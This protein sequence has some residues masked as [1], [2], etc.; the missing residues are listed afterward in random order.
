MAETNSSIILPAPLFTDPRSLKALANGTFYVGAVDTD[1]TS[2]TNQIPV[3]NRNEDGSLV[4]VSQPINIGTGGYPVFNGIPFAPIVDGNYSIAIFDAIGVQRFYFP[5]VSAYQP[6]SPSLSALADLTPAANKVPYFT[7]PDSAA[8]ADLTPFARE[9]LAQP[10][11]ASVVSKI[12]LQN[13]SKSRMTAFLTAGVVSFT[14]PDDV[15]RIYGRAIGG[16]G[17]A[18]GSASAKSGGGGGA[19]GYSEGYFNVTPGQVISITVGTQGAGGTPGNFG[20]SGGASSIG[21]FMSASG[22]AYGDAG[23]GGTG[24]GGFGGSGTGGTFNNVGG[25][26]ADGTTTGAVGGG[27]GGGAALGGST[28][29]GGTGRN[30]L[31]IGGGGAASYVAA[32]QAGGNGRSGAVILEY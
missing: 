14:V 19:G 11:A 2:P 22:G 16:G 30:A 24:A 1:P 21:S 18:G 28:R 12:G 23:G 17:G 15:Y 20:T 26:G 31:S 6:T 10:N 4:Q 29:S 3:Y 27:A 7:G 8:L 32:S 5:Y 25:D 9:I 13:V